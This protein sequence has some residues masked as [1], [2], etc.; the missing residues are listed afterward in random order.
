MNRRPWSSFF[1]FC[2][3]GRGGDFGSVLQLQSC[4]NANAAIFP[5]SEAKKVATL[6]AQMKLFSSLKKCFKIAIDTF[7]QRA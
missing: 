5:F 7:K 2:S 1:F 6:R 4:P 3:G